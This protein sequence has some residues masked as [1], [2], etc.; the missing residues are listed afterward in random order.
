M[1]TDYNT[2]KIT[3]AYNRVE[4]NELTLKYSYL[5]ISTDTIELDIGYSFLANEAS[6]SFKLVGYWSDHTQMICNALPFWHAGR[7]EETSNYQQLINSM[8]M[9]AEYTYHQFLLARKNAF[10]DLAETDVIHSGYISDYPQEIPDDS[11]RRTEN[12]LYNSDFAIPSRAISD[13]PCQWSIDK[14]TGSIVKLS[15]SHCLSAGNALQVQTNSGEYASIYQSYSAKASAG[16][17]IVLSAFVNIPNNSSLV[18]L[19]ASGSAALHL[20]VLYVDGTFDQTSIDIPL[21]TTEEGILSDNSTGQISYWRRIHGSISLSKPSA[22]VKCCIKSDYTNSTSDFLAYIDCIQLEIGTIPT[23]W[24]NSPR[25]ILPWVNPTELSDTTYD[26]YS[27]NTSSYSQSSIV[28][29]SNT[30]YMDIRPKTK[31]NLCANEESFYNNAIPT[32]L[33]SVTETAENGVSHNTRGSITNI[34]DILLSSIKWEPHRSDAS[35]ISKTSLRFRDDH[36]SFSISERDYFG[37]DIDRYTVIKDHMSSGAETYTLAIRALTVDH[38]YLVAFC[39]ESLGARVYYT[40]KF[41][42]P[43]KGP[44]GTYL[45]CIQDFKVPDTTASLFDTGVETGSVLFSQIGKVEGSRSKFVIETNDGVTKYGTN[46]AYDYYIDAGDG[47][48]FTREK[49]DQICVT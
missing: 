43:N 34:Y 9:N 7:Y 38:D 42:S 33:I 2:L 21:S 26:V 11:D 19:N 12:I 5:P 49:Y 23:R 6:T 3:Y 22:Y 29:N 16:Q 37:D 17:N 39:R 41:I 20:D 27:N 35:K 18:D 8:A 31:I 40:F 4:Y 32:R 44:Q 24:K 13:T 47:Q 46:F 36:G 10:I 30:S 25:D 15:E 14:S 48:F 28:L 1:A 45:E